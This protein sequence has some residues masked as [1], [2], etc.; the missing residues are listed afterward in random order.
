MKGFIKFYRK[1]AE[2]GSTSTYTSAAF[3]NAKDN[4]IGVRSK[5]QMLLN[6]TNNLH[7]HIYANF[8]RLLLS[9]R[10][11][12]TCGFDCVFCFTVQWWPI[13]CFP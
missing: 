6:H 4:P 7:G 3:W 5:T 10:N 13:C 8:K 1:P 12:D 2:E 9:K 11:P